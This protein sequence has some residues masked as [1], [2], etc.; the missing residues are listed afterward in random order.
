M[1]W[2]IERVDNTFAITHAPYGF[3]YGDAAYSKTKQEALDKFLLELTVEISRQH[4]KLDELF[5]LKKIAKKIDIDDVFIE[6][7]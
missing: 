6:R 3:R 1:M 2:K 5:L 7:R 4:T